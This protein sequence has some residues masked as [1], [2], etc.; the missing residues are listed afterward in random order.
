[1]KSFEWVSPT[2]VGDAVKFLQPS[3]PVDADESPLPLAGGQDLLT[4][5]KDYIV[6]PPR[7]VNLKGIPGLN[8]IE[9]GEKSLKVGAL[10]TLAE[11]EDHAEIRK[12]FP[13]LAEAAH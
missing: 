5:M 1:M 3:G 7:V 12:R 11:V 10:A 9:F 6:R 2:N 8:K 4:A 13:G